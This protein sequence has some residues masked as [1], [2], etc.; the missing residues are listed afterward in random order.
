MS[1]IIT[2]TRPSNAVSSQVYVR[3]PRFVAWVTTVVLVMLIL[4]V[5]E[6]N[7]TDVMNCDDPKVTCSPRSTA[8]T[9]ATPGRCSQHKFDGA[10]NSGHAIPGTGI[11]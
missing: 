7:A 9:C 1:S 6:A 2:D 8:E 4:G 5:A 11:F 10:F 3:G